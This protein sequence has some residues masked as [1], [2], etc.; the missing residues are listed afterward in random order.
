MILLNFKKKTDY[1]YLSFLFIHKISEMMPTAALA[2]GILGLKT[3][4][5]QVNEIMNV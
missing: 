3:V 4:F 2:L 1:I 5:V